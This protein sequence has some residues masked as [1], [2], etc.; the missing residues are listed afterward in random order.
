MFVINDG[1][2]KVSYVIFVYFGKVV[3]DL[4]VVNNILLI[5]K[6]F[7][8]KKV[9]FDKFGEILVVVYEIEGLINE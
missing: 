5:L 4:E 7:K 9:R 6:L 1:K 3:V 8:F 2:L